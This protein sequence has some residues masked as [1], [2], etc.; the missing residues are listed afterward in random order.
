[1]QTLSNKPEHDNNRVQKQTRLGQISFIN[2]LPVSLPLQRGAIKLDC[3]QVY[4]TPARLNEKL[5]SGELV[6]GAMSSFYFLE[7]GRFELFRDISIS[8]QGKVGSVI[9]YSK[10]DLKALQQKTVLVPNS[11]ATSIKLMQLLLKDEYGVELKLE[12]QNGKSENESEQFADRQDLA[13]LLLIGDRA[14]KQDERLSAANHLRIDL[15]QW[16]FNRFGLPFV[17]GV[18]GARKDWAETNREE[19][20]RISSSLIEASRLGLGSMFEEVV[21]EA[22]R[23][24]GLPTQRLN[25]YYQNELDYRL[26]DEHDQSLALFGSLCKQHSLFSDS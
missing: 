18:W 2:T 13:G 17:F 20:Q 7:D 23:I 25:C 12:T 3:E 14:L 19:F 5:K 22:V 6:L 11:S 15:A 1:M 24:S 16:W 26:K 10:T 21:S 8:G 4:D 9:L